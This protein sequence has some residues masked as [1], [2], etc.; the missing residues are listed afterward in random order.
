MCSPI[1]RELDIEVA[2]L[3][4][5]GG[6]M[7][8]AR[9]LVYAVCWA[10]AL[11]A[12][13]LSLAKTSLKGVS[14]S[15]PDVAR[16]GVTFKKVPLIAEYLRSLGT[17]ESCMAAAAA[18]LQFD[19]Y[20]RPATLLR[21]K[22]KDVHAPST[23]KVA[24]PLRSW[25]MVFF[26]T[27]ETALSKSRTQDDTVAVGAS[28]AQL[29]WLTPVCEALAA[30]SGRDGPQALMFRVSLPAYRGLL[31]KAA[32]HLK[33]GLI[34]PHMLRHGGASYDAVCGAALEAVRLRGQ[35]RHQ[36]SCARYMKFGRYVRRR[37]SLSASMIEDSTVA[38][39]RLKKYLAN[40]IRQRKP[41]VSHRAV[42]EKL[43]KI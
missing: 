4:F 20:Q 29:T 11:K 39:A 33:L 22:I 23:G 24:A 43:N 1:D 5:A 19:S 21:V 15:E 16:N 30:T 18:L 26:P 25:T 40:D 9:Y 8:Q 41:T 36:N 13:S 31:A 35:W 32:S 2:K 10:W 38:L 27:T 34:T 37:S 7:Q 42:E 14:R 3:Y 17:I 28:A 6:S 12:S